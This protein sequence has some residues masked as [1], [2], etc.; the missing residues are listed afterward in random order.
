MRRVLVF[1]LLL[2]LLLSAC[3]GG[4]TS[5]NGLEAHEAWTRPAAQGQNGDVYFVFHNHSSKPDELIGAATDVAEA[6][7]IQD[8]TGSQ[9]RSVPVK[10]FADMEFTANGPHLMLVNLKKELKLSDQFQ[11]ILHFKNSKDIKIR[12]SVRTTPPPAED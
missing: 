9:V 12:V 10:A 4:S 7:E 8:S 5:G 3:G 11:I 2:P 6:V 1:V